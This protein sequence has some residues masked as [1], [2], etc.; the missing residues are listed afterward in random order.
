MKVRC[1]WEHNGSDSLLYSTDFVGAFTRGASKEIAESKMEDEIRSYLRW[2]N[3]VGVKYNS[4]KNAKNNTENEIENNTAKNIDVGS[5]MLK[6]EVEIARDCPSDLQIADADS[7]VL[8][9]DERKPLTLEE[10]TELKQLALKS[11]ADF[12][13]LY[14]SIPDKDVS[15][16]PERKTFYGAVPRTAREMYEHTKN[17]NSYYFGEIEIDADNKGS[18]L[19]CREKGFRLLENTEGF[20]KNA[21]VEGSYGELWSP[22]KVLRRFIW[23]DR[24]HAKAMYRMAVKTFGRD[25]IQDIFCFE[26]CFSE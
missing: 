25:E 21:V 11:A 7:D 1:V 19:E 6:I 8:F 20:L 16:L 23:H 5:E 12:L 15:C 26:G 14:E 2:K 22:R 9:D 18:I 3:G 17:V 24:I 13:R 4:G 10:Y